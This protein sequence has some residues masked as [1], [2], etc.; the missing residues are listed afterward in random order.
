M[1]YAFR[2]HI[3]FCGKYKRQTL[4]SFHHKKRTFHHRKLHFYHNDAIMLK[5]GRDWL[6]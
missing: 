5:N 4:I 6:I 1:S 3:L 2:G